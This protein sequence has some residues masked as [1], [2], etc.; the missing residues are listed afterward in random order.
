MCEKNPLEYINK[1]LFRKNCTNGQIHPLK[2]MFCNYKILLVQPPFGGLLSSSC[3]RLYLQSPTEGPFGP[4]GDAFFFYYMVRYKCTHCE[5]GYP[6]QLQITRESGWLG[7]VKS[8]QAACNCISHQKVILPWCS[9][10]ST[11]S[12]RPWSACC[13][14]WILGQVMS[15]KFCKF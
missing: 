5:W 7:L 10:L 15:Y 11:S 9:S 3:G 4:K 1:K 6:F 12:C 14:T 8:G 2:K 13:C